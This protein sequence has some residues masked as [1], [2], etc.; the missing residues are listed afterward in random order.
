VKPGIAQLTRREMVFLLTSFVAAPMTSIAGRDPGVTSAFGDSRVRLPGYPSHRPGFSAR[1][2][3]DGGL[4]LWVRDS[5][6]VTT[7]YR[8]NANGRAIWALCDGRRSKEEIG[9]IYQTRTGRS[10]TEAID[11][12]KSL[13]VFGPVVVGGYVVT[14]GTFPR[15]PEDGGY[16]VLLENLSVT[17]S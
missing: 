9:A 5:D 8:L 14:K 12:L 16:H 10:G 3:Q 7:G 1:G 11:F 13:I 2:L 15:A 17:E 4:L 6:G